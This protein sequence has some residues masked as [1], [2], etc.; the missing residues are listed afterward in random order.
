MDAGRVDRRAITGLERRA[1]QFAAEG[2]DVFE[3]AVHAR[4]HR[5][6]R[7]GDFIQAVLAGVDRPQ[8]GEHVFVG[9]E[10]CHRTAIDTG[11]HIVGLLEFG[12]Q[13]FA[14][15]VPDPQVFGDVLEQLVGFVLLLECLAG[16]VAAQLQSAF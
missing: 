6:G 1:F 9:G 13:R 4:F 11:L 5:L 7:L 3:P 10:E 12:D 15:V 2:G 14:N 16:L 8:D